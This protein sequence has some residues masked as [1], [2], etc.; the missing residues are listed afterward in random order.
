MS[1]WSALFDQARPAFAEHRTFERA[2]SL[3]VSALAC[4][5]RRTLSGL[6][7]TAGLQFHDWSAAYR[8]FERERMDT[9]QLWRVSTRAVLDALPPSAPVAAGIVAMGACSPPR[10]SFVLTTRWPGTVSAPSPRARS[11]TLIS[12]GSRRSAG[13]TPAENVNCLY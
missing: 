11:M 1:A 4:L 3:A 12:S 6:L 10:N 9:E 2:R 13:S 7:C 8:L 5:G